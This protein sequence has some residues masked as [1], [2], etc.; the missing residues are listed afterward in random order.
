M[1]HLDHSAAADRPK[2]RYSGSRRWGWFEGTVRTEWLISGRD[3]FTLGPRVYVDHTE[4]RWS[5]P[6]H[7]IINGA[8]VPWFFRRVFPAYVGKYRYATVVHDHYCTTKIVPSW[9]VHR[10]FYEAM[11]CGGTGPLTAWLMWAA[12]RC[13]GP[14]FRGRLK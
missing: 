11:R 3:M 4:K 9:Q 14:R 6:I 5:V 7:S 8:S 1:S 10:M 13:F 2:P 12:V